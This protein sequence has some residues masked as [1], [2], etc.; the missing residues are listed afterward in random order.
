MKIKKLNT[1]NR[2]RQEMKE[3]RK[4]YSKADKR[5]FTDKNTKR[6]KERN[7]QDTQLI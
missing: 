1:Y 6:D 3:S 7:Y 5:V 2:E 4:C